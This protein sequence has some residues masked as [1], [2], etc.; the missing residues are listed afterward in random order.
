MKINKAIV[1]KLSISIMIELSK[2]DRFFVKTLMKK[3]E[4]EVEFDALL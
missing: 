3:I 2:L 1:Q 4:K